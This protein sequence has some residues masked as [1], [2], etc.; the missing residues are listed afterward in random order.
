MRER[1]LLHL[2]Q[3]K[4]DAHAVHQHYALIDNVLVGD[5]GIHELTKRLEGTDEFDRF[6]G[7]LGFRRELIEHGDVQA[8]EFGVVWYFCQEC[9]QLRC[10]EQVKALRGTLI[11][12]TGVFIE[13]LWV[14]KCQLKKDLIAKN[15]K[16][17][18]CVFR[19][20][21]LFCPFFPQ[22]VKL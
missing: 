22:R 8:T 14:A 21:K 5:L 11:N 2:L 10:Q 3:I 1:L 7:R 19:Q 20:M 12:G 6:G 16:I 4:R 9:L 13:A 15:H 17:R 18:G